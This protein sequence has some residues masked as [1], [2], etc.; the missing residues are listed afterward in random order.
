MVFISELKDNLFNHIEYYTPCQCISSDYA[1]GRGIAVEMNRVFNLRKHLDYYCNSNNL[2]KLLYPSCVY[3]GGVLNLVT[4]DRYFQKPTYDT[5]EESLIQMSTI[6]ESNS[7]ERVVMPTIGCGL[8]KLEWK[9]V[10]QMLFNVFEKNNLY[11]LVC[12]K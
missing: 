6:I 8:D 7:I 4:K 10:K 1:M 12:I 3:S 5:L 2:Y 9:I 11:I